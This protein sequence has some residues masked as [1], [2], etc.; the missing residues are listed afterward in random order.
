MEHTTEQYVNLSQ[1]PGHKTEYVNHPSEIEF[2]Y[3]SKPQPTV[4]ASDLSLQPDPVYDEVPPKLQSPVIN[5]P[6]RQYINVSHTAEDSLRYKLEPDANTQQTLPA[7]LEGEHDVK[8]YHSDIIYDEVPSLD[9][10]IHTTHYYINVPQ[11]PP[12]AT[13]TDY[14]NPDFEKL[15]LKTQSVDNQPNY[16]NVSQSPKPVTKIKKSKSLT[17]QPWSTTN[18]DDCHSRP[19]ASPRHH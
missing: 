18:S 5:F 11:S 19:L 12:V 3:R 4:G 14:A 9:Q 16:M 2:S 15:T 1:S 17:S 10:S 6:T 13:D 8:S 7:Q